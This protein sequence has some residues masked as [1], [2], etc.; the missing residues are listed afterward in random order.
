VPLTANPTLDRQFSD[1]FGPTWEQLSTEKY[2]E[3]LEVNNLQY[4]PFRSTR[5]SFFDNLFNFNTTANC[6]FNIPYLTTFPPRIIGNTS[7]VIHTFYFDAYLPPSLPFGSLF[8]LENPKLPVIIMMHGEVEDKGA[9]NANMTSQYLARQGYLV[10]DLNYGYL[11]TN[12][13]GNNYTGYYFRDLVRQIG[14]FTQFLDANNEEYHAD[15]SKVYFS[16]RHLGGGLALLC[17]MGYNTTLQ[18][19]FSPNLRVSGIIPFYPVSDIGTDEDFFKIS[20]MYYNETLISGSSDPLAP[21]F[22]PDWELL[23]PIRMLDGLTGS[24]A[25]MFFI[26]GTH[27]WIISIRYSTPFI[28]LLRK[29]GY[30]FILGEYLF[31][32]DGFDGAHLSPY[33]QSIIY[34]LERFLALTV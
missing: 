28:D 10:C 1:N 2:I 14:N 17:G 21:N 33:G 25:P 23:N 3:R 6:R 16:G 30:S 26:T 7:T 32:N 8:P 27:D 24:L 34:Y 4:T 29:K 9:W 18:D 11:R 15:L 22:N 5:Y 19:Y 20:V 31:G 12:N 13:L